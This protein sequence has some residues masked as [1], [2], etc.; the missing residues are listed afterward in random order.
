MQNQ[1]T[2][3]L[4]CRGKLMDLSNPLIMGVLN[5]TSDSFYDGGKHLTLTEQLKQIEKMLAEGADII[6]VGAMSSRPGASLS[7]PE[8]E[9]KK[10]LPLIQKAIQQFPEI[11]I[12]VDTIHAKVAEQVLEA[13]AHIIND[14]SAG[15]FDK[16]MLSIMAQFKNAPYI[17]MHMKGTPETMQQNT[18]YDN[19]MVNIVD[20]FVERIYLARQDGIL[21]VL[22]DP[23]IGFSKTID[24]NY[25]LLN[26][27]SELQILD[28]PLLVG[29]S[30]K[31]LIWKTLK[32]TAKEALNGT[33]VLNTVALLNG[34]HIL[35]VHDVKEAKE[36]LT[37]VQK[38]KA[39]A[40]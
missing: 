40:Q 9:L 38:L 29:I 11:I 25:E 26:R 21:D 33:S 3:T 18:N 2:Y 12:S 20:Y 7:K 13:G 22:V 16:V 30:R 35:R 19:L 39:Q 36:T 6:D 27:L 31:S 5:I 32:C 28:C 1:N 15:V 8:D 34:A 14:I 24:Q 10:L 37:L 4:N 17:M 23:G